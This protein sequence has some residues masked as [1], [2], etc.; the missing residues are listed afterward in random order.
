ML[1]ITGVPFFKFD[2]YLSIALVLVLDKA[3]RAARALVLD[4]ALENSAI[5]VEDILDVLV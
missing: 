3:E 5:L 4:L 1:K 2:I